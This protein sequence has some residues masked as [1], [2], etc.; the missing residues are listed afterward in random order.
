[1]NRSA[2]VA[3]LLT[4]ILVASLALTILAISKKSASPEEKQEALASLFGSWPPTKGNIVLIVGFFGG[5]IL[6]GWWASR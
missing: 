5:V 2:W 1:M 4:G 6:L 3:L